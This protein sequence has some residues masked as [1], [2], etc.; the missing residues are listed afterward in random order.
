M[1]KFLM[2]GKYSS[3]ALKEIGAERTKKAGELF[4]K[5]G[6]KLESAY[7]LTGAYDIVLIVELPGLEE[8]MKASISLTK[9]TGI[10]FSTSQ[11]VPVGDFDRMAAEI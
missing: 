8:A 3:E 9:M 10:S 7:A 6:G 4:E 2:M 11:A 5:F 1:A